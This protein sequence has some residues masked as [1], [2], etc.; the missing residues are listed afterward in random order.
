MIAL[1]VLSL[2]LELEVPVEKGWVTVQV[3]THVYRQYVPTAWGT[4]YEAYMGL[5]TGCVACFSFAIFALRK[6]TRR[7]RIG[8]W[9]ETLRP[10]LTAVAMTGMGAAITALATPQFLQCDD[11]R[12]GAIAGLVLSSLLF[13]VL[14]FARGRRVRPAFVVGNGVQPAP[15]HGADGQPGVADEQAPAGAAETTPDE[16]PNRGEPDA[17]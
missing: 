12:A 16:R 9:R 1:F 17:G 14:L 13:V 4:D 7:K 6:T 5:I 15:A 3:G 10:F 8:F 11:D 2:V